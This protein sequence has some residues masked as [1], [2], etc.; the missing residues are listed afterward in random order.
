MLVRC[1]RDGASDCA[2]IRLRCLSSKYTQLETIVFDA[3]IPKQ[4]PFASP[5]GCNVRLAMK[6]AG[7]EKFMFTAG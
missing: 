6:G 7:I 4:A 3:V 5:R 1:Q 2:Q